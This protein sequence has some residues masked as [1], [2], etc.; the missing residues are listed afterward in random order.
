MQLQTSPE[1]E[2]MDTLRINNAT[3]SCRNYSL[4]RVPLQRPSSTKQCLR[5]ELLALKAR[6]AESVRC[7][8]ALKRR[9]T[10][11]D[12]T[13]RR[14]VIPR[15]DAAY[16]RRAQQHGLQERRGIKHTLV[17]AALISVP[18]VPVRPG[19]R[20]TPYRDQQPRFCPSSAKSNIRGH[21]HAKWALDTSMSISANARTS[22]ATRIACWKGA[23]STLASAPPRSSAK[24]ANLS[25]PYAAAH[26]DR[27]PH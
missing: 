24:S 25:K 8:S 15:A 7:G 22:S 2:P 18:A 26:A 21:G 9:F 20:S 3:K 1:R 23:A 12:A 5:R 14:V 17:S 4:A 11:E 10:E 27:P 19:C 16:G 13:P 6:A